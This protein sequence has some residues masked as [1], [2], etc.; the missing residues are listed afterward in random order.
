MSGVLL[1]VAFYAILRFKAV[2][3]LAVGPGFAAGSAGHR[4]AAFVGRGRLAA[5][6]PTRLQADARLP[7]HRAHGPHRSRRRGGY[8]PGHRRRAAP[9]PWPRPGQER[10]V[11]DLRRDHGGRGH[12]PDRRGPGLAGPASRSR[13]GVRH[14]AGGPARA[15]ALQPVQQRVAHGP[16]RVPGRVGLGRGGGDC[17]HGGD[18]RRRRRS[19][20]PHAPR[21][22]RDSESS[23]HRRPAGWPRPWSGAWSV[24]GFIGVFAWPLSGLLEAAAHVV[25]P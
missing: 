1:T 24:C 9:H 21:P 23:R 18:L 4:G 22:T 12:Q 17:G 19:C 2:V 20:P 11:P 8:P 13:W 10:A 5:A 25:A 14:R 6:H 3:D 16:S 7:Q 15:P